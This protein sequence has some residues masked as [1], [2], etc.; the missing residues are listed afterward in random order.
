MS[1]EINKWADFWLDREIGVHECGFVKLID[2]MGG[3]SRVVEAARCS[4]GGMSKPT[5]SK[6]D[7]I[8]FLMKHRHLSPFEQTVLT[9]QIKMPIF[10]ARQLVRYRTGRINE[11]S[12]R[13]STLPK[14]FYIPEHLVSKDGVSIDADD[15]SIVISTME[16][17]QDET[18]RSYEFYLDLGLARE[19]ARINL[20]VSTY[21]T[22]MWQMDLRNL[23]HFLEQRLSRHAQK[24]IRDYADVIGY[25]TCAVAPLSYAA[26]TEHVLHSV[27]LSE[28]E[29]KNLYTAL[30]EAGLNP[31]SFGLGV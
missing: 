2:Y 18:A 29:V 17:D 21:T 27:T 11:Q 16:D 30:S 9:F 13:Y 28:N 31:S 26:F 7:L 5:S 19:Q 3:D 23:F 14:E 12:A 6:E 8:Q 1:K 15:A 22:M 4:L 20:P 24:E 10:V 25:L